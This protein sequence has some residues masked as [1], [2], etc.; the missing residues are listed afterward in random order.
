M[1]PWPIGVTP[2]LTSR[3]R[4]LERRPG[5]LLNQSFARLMSVA[6]ATTIQARAVLRRC[7][8]RSN[9][10]WGG[11]LSGVT[12]LVRGSPRLDIVIRSMIRANCLGHAVT[13]KSTAVHILRVGQDRSRDSGA[14]WLHFPTTRPRSAENL[15]IG[16]SG[17]LNSQV[18]YQSP[19]ELAGSGD[20]VC[21]LTAQNDKWF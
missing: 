6:L 5:G 18:P 21:D 8:G 10:N 11:A 7:P 1:S 15:R 4:A 9:G 14:A 13:V 2:L 20:G 17:C 16:H 12:A 19:R 3:K